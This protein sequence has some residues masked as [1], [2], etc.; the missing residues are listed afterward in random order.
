MAQTLAELA[1]DGR[2][3]AGWADALAPVQD[4]ITSLG[5]RLRSEQ[6]AGHG[7]LP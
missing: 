5:E 6:E 4:T 3:D 1:T 2:I 7:Y